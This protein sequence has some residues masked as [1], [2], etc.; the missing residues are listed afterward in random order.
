M[1]AFEDSAQRVSNYNYIGYLTFSFSILYNCIV[2]IVRLEIHN[3][4]IA[5]KINRR[6][7]NSETKS[8]TEINK[9]GTES[10]NLA[11][12][13]VEIGNLVFAKL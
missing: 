12:I 5:G 2:I 3:N 1:M 13:K 8:K 7:D 10:E 6:C 11:G 4:K 9:S